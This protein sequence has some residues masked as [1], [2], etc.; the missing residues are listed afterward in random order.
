MLLDNDAF[1]T[2]L[3]KLFDSTKQTGT[4]YVTFKTIT[5]TEVKKKTKNKVEEQQCLVRATDGKSGNKKTKIST[6][7]RAKD[8][9]R[10]QMQYNTLM[11]AH[12]D[13]L[14][15]KTKKRKMKV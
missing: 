15:K 1:L 13:G 8:V 4:V 14:N 11:K 7:L 2:A 6:L 5:H 3:T 12:M 10:F 9:N